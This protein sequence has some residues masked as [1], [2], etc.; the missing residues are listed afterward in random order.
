MLILIIA[1]MNEATMNMNM[2]GGV[3]SVVNS[4]LLSIVLVQFLGCIDEDRKE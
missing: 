2:H 3:P 1:T 4:V